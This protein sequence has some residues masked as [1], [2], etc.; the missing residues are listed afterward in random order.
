MHCNTKF[1]QISNQMTIAQTNKQTKR[2]LC[3]T[4][5]LRHGKTY[6][7]GEYECTHYTLY[8]FRLESI[9][10]NL[11]RIALEKKQRQPLPLHAMNTI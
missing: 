3:D 5:L 7:T 11:M 4:A 6:Y 1:E 8:T 2:T 9:R 10:V